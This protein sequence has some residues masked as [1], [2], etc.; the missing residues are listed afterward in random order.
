[1][2][3]MCINLDEPADG[4]GSGGLATNEVAQNIW[5]PS[6]QQTLRG[7][8]AAP[9]GATRHPPVPALAPMRFREDEDLKERR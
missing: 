1:M 4:G 5:L 2:M 9:T 6:T 3:Q 8:A 7:G